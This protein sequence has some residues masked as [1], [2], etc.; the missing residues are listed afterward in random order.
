MSWD[1]I[2]KGTNGADYLSGGSGDDLIQGRAGGDTID[3]GTGDD[4]LHGDAGDDHLRGGAGNDFISG[5]IGIDTAYYSG[6]VLHYSHYRVGEELFLSH[7]AGTGAD[8]KDR[9]LHVE[10]LVFADA[11]IDLTQNNGP[12]AFADTASTNE[13]V[14]TYSSGSGSVLDNDFDWEG[15]ALS[16]TP[17]TFNGV[18]GKLVLQSN[19]TYTYTPYASAQ[20][21]AQGQTVQEVF[22]YTVSDGSLTATGTLTINLAGRNDAPVAAPDVASTGENSAVTVNVL[23][24]DTDVDNG[25]ILS[26][27]AASAPAG[28]GTATVVGNQVR[29]DPGTD[30]DH[31]AA[32]ATE[33]VVVNYTI[34]DEHGA[35]SSSTVTVTV[36]GTNDEPVASADS[37]SGH[38]NQVLTVDV[39]ANDSDVDEGAFLTVTAASAPAGKGTAS[40]VGNQV[41]F[42]PGDDFD[43][44]AEGA[45]E[46]V[47]VSY[48]IEDDHNASASSTVTITVTGT[49]DGPVANADSGSTGEN[50]AVTVDVLANDTDADDGAVLTVV[51]AS[52]SAGQGSV[53]VVANQVKFDPGTDFDYL[54]AGESAEVEIGYTIEDEHGASSS[55][56]LTVT[57][58]GANDAPTIDSAGTTAT[59]SASELAN[60]DANEGTQVH[61][62][63]GT[64]AFDDVDLSDTH[65]ASVTPQGGGYLG[66]FTLD[67]VDQNGDGV[68]WDFSVSDAALDSLDEGEV[69]TQTYTIEIDDGNGGT[70]S[71][72]V[73]ITLTGAGDN[74]PPDAVDDSYSA[75]GNVTL[76][77]NAAD[78]VLAN[79]SD[80]AG[81]GD[82]PGETPVTA[83]DSVSANGGT[84]TMNPDGSFSYTSAP[85]F[86]GSDSFT[87]TITDA[88]G[89]T[90]T[91][92]VT[93]SVTGGVW[94]IDNSAVGSANLGTQ[95]DPYTS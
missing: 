34:Q 49:N 31:L 8:G 19:G 37:A 84:V 18:Y 53:S 55:S 45:S 28:K 38:E 87:Y 10:R 71:Q 41:R 32:G 48:T 60:G 78:G 91:A 24:N 79:D 27:V 17:G 1:D 86:N 6:S 64:V 14:G 68:G 33:T 82:G 42:D 12:I 50:S 35:A 59:G 74:L 11:I 7:V 40:V 88:E 15:S 63:S 36:T 5:G 73:T 44:L 75:M 83:Y 56:T 43:H 26:V 20:A 62:A 69:V 9:L 92:T 39:L 67:P 13:D 47:V 46:I 51:A 16:A 81:V 21:L 80:D 2:L 89:E 66:T 76:T 95:A 61:Q 77:V 54:A 30:F 58:N 93:V 72:D 22:T 4:Q 65:S 23:A 3:G 52:G 94:F 85:G 29:F 25:S 90:D 57:V 70:T